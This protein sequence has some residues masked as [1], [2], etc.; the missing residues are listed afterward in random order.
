MPQAK[1]S[2]QLFPGVKTRLSRTVIP[3][4]RK[5]QGEQPVTSDFLPWGTFPDTIR[6][7][8]AQTKSG[9]LL[10]LRKQTETAI[11]GWRLRRQLERVGQNIWEEGLHGGQKRRAV[12]FGSLAEGWADTC[13]V[14][15]WKA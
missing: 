4:K 11:Q 1:Y 14:R 7:V 3:E 5:T 6:G 13:K 15:F 2:R 10:E 8:G 9:S 12:P